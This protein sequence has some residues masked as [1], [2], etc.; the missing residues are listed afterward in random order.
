[1]AV[2]RHQSGTLIYG[3]ARQ[4][5][6]FEIICSSAGTLSEILSEVSLNFL[7]FGT[8]RNTKFRIQATERTARGCSS[9]S[10]GL[11]TPRPPLFI[12]CV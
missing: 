5:L 9:R 1:M 8:L 4:R 6:T 12:T 11:C 2:V 10:S 7:S 3:E